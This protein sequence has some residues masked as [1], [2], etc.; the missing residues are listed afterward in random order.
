MFSASA[1]DGGEPALQIDSGPLKSDQVFR[2]LLPHVEPIWVDK[3]FRF[4]DAPANFL[5]SVDKI[6]KLA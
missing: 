1:A 5:K 6:R 4:V 2:N 3:E